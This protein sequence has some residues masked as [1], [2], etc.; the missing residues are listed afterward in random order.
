MV[1]FA[2]DVVQVA[3]GAYCRRHTTTSSAS[4]SRT[5]LLERAFRETYG[6]E[7]KDVFASE[8]LAIGTFRYAVGTV[9]PQM[10]Q[11]AWEKKRDEIERCRP[12]VQR[13]A[14]MYTLYAAAVRHGL[15]SDVPASRRIRALRCLDRARAAEDRSVQGAG[16]QGAE[17]RSGAPLH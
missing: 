5:D 6:L 10:T 2:F 11:V 12:S 14:F 3:N 7:M 9:I 17:C 15:R 8:D 16:V 1:E 13:S 4:R